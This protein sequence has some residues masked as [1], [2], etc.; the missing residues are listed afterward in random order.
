MISYES[1]SDEEAIRTCQTIHDLDRP[2]SF[3]LTNALSGKV[4]GNSPFE[5][6]G[7]RCRPPYYIDTPFPTM[8]ILTVRG[9]GKISRTP[10][11]KRVAVRSTEKFLP[12]RWDSET[13]LF[14]GESK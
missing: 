1:I 5:S 7:V 9:Q 3:T 11:V 2:T 13:G 6:R 8:R 10:F 4:Y 14:I 12:M